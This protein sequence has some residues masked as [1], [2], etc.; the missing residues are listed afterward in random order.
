MPLLLFSARYP[1]DAGNEQSFLEV[2]IQRLANEFKPVILVPRNTHGERVPLPAGV[3]VEDSYARSLNRPNP[4][5]SVW[6][7]LSSP[8]FYRDLVSYPSILIHPPA[9]FRLAAYIVGASLTSRWVEN[10]MKKSG[11]A[12]DQLLFYSYWFDQACMGIGG[13]KKRYPGIRLVTR[14]HGYDLYEEYHYKPAFWPCR[15]ATLSYLDRLFTDSRTGESYLRQKY[16]EFAGIYQTSLQGVPDPGFLN[17]PSRDGVFRVVSCSMIKGVKRVELLFEGFKRAAELR[18]EHKF[19]WRHIGNGDMRSMIQKMADETLP[20]NA[21]AY[22]PGYTDKET[23]YRLYRE[24]PLDVFVNVSVTE[25]TPVSIM[26]AI[27]CGL[28]VIA[29]SVGGNQEIVSEENGWLLSENPPPDEI[30]R[31]ILECVDQ[32]EQAHKKR[33]A[34]RSLWAQQYHAED[35][36]SIFVQTIKKIRDGYSDTICE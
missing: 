12:P 5:L 19:E 1:Y 31:A 7:V 34:S 11:Y 24:T 17:R 23:L 13:L 25:G 10:W 33:E 36:F 26:E 6:S 2:E 16:P 22:L 32:P 29:T 27:S 4:L 14:A 35:N 21:R 30:A 28:P 8:C 9:L 20:P 15:R 3:E 18:P